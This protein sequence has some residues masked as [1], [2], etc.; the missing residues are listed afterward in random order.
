MLI[1]SK[2]QI[3]YLGGYVNNW[4]TKSFSDYVKSRNNSIFIERD[5]GG[6]GQGYKDDDGSI[7]FDTDVNYA[8]IKDKRD[9]RFQPSDGYR[10]SFNQKIPLYSE[11]PALLN[12]LDYS[13][14]HSFSENLVTSIRFHGRVI[15]SIQDTDDVKISQRIYLPGRYLRGFEAGK[16][17]PVDS[18]DYVGGNYATALGFNAQL[19]NALPTLSN[20]DINLFIDAANVWGVDYDAA[21]DDSNK[22][23]SAF[24]I[25]ADWFTPIGPLNFS[26]AQ[27]ISK[28]S[29]DKTESFRFNIGT[30]F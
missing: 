20:L 2:N 9:R 23:R 12:G 30:T 28:A 19:P 4:T 3:D 16:I 14:Y 5:H 21:I 6:P 8:I 22:I 13:A 1:A 18:T 11:N 25:S 10:I 29:T 7:S 26:L 24:G 15:K 27:D 17:G